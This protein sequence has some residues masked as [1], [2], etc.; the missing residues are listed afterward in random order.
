[1]QFTSEISRALKS[2]ANPER[3]AASANFFPGMRL[4]LLGLSVPQIRAVEKS[5]FSFSELPRKKQLEIFDATYRTTDIF[6]VRS[7]PLLYLQ[8]TKKQNDI[9]IW[10]LTRKWAQLLDNWEHSNRLSDIFND[11]LN[12]FPDV[13]YPILKK[14][15][16]SK[17]PWERRQS[18]VSLFL[19]Y[20]P[21]KLVLPKSKIFPLITRLLHD[22]HPYVQKAVGWTMRETRH[23][24]PDATWRYLQ[25]YAAVISPTAWYAATE[26]LTPATKQ[27]L[28]MLRRKK[29]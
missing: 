16:A 17:N 5:G 15:N 14:W 11:L 2:F 6:E 19:Y 12:K 26:R 28:L 3:A 23:A 1:M 10:Q 27:H 20:R 18:L 9:S 4:R 22:P 25:K 24:Y 21:N 7:I 13:V 8:R 29:I